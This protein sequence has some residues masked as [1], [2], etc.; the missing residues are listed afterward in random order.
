M[1]KVLIILLYI[2]LGATTGI[3]KILG[4]FPPNWFREKFSDSII[5]WVPGGIELSFGIIVFLELAIAGLFTIALIKREFA[6]GTP[7]IYS[8]LGFY[9]SLLLFLILFFGSFLIQ[10]YDNGF[11]DFVYFGVTL[12]LMRYFMKL[13]TE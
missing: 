1:E 4:P 3:H 7:K 10:N 11:F 9:F 2:A 8:Q 6:I 5:G 13:E 12:Y